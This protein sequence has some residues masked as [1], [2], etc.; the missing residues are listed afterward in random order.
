MEKSKRL[1]PDAQVCERYGIHISTLY[2]WDHNPALGFPKPIRINKRKFR[3]E[4][5][6]DHFDRERAAE[7]QTASGA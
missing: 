1:L 5:E 4:T 7:R 6:L 3:D 2:N